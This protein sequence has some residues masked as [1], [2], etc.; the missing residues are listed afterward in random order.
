M[1][2]AESGTRAKGR[3]KATVSSQFKVGKCVLKFL[4]YFHFIH[5]IGRKFLCIS[6]VIGLF[7]FI[8]QPTLA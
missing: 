4:E 7:S 5:S 3:K 8:C 1:G 6:D 2:G